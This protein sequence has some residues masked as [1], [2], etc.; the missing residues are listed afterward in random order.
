MVHRRSLL[1]FCCVLSLVVGGLIGYFTPH[2]ATRPIEVITPDPTATPPPTATPL[3][4]RVYVCGAVAQP[5][6]YRLPPGSLVDD[7]IRAAGGPTGDADLIRINLAMELRDQQQVIVPRVG[8]ALPAEAVS[9]GVAPTPPIEP[10]RLNT[11][12]A[13]ELETLPGIGPSLA[14]RIVEYR[15]TYGPFE[16]L[17][18]LLNVPGVGPSILEGLRDRVVID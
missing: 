5:G 13:A 7:A 10:V 11:A 6:V 3:P 8:E 15:D 18:D 12:T 9:E 2:P 16:T 4:L 17:E 1:V 14:R